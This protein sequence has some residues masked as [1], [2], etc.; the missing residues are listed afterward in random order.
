MVGAESCATIKIAISVSQLSK[1]TS[2]LTVFHLSKL[3]ISSQWILR[4]DLQKLFFIINLAE[5]V[6]PSSSPHCGDVCRLC[7]VRDFSGLQNMFCGIAHM[8]LILVVTDVV[9]QHGRVRD[10]VKIIPSCWH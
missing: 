4:F 1:S 10:I 7:V 8:W 2:F 5:S 9:V 3:G 6:I